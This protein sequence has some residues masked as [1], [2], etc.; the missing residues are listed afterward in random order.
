MYRISV[1]MATRNEGAIISRTLASIKWADELVLVDSGS[2]DDTVEIAK[3]YGAKVFQE[4]WKGYGAQVN[5]ALDKC[6]SPWILTLD[7]DEVV[8]K[9]L[10]TEIRSL[11]LAEPE[12]DAYTVPR[13]NFVLG[14]AMLHGGLYP[15]RRLRLFRNGAAR[16][17]EDEEHHSSPVASVR[18]GR[19]SSPL[20]HYQYPTLDLYL[21]HM[22]RYSTTCV[23]RL[24]QQKEVGERSLRL[25]WNI[26][27][28][29][30]WMFFKNYVLRAGF[31]DGR[32]ALIY[33]LNHSLYVHWK[34]VKAWDACRRSRPS[35]MQISPA[36]WEFHHDHS[37]F[38]PLDETDIEAPKSERS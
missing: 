38:F 16:L 8:S 1:A 4:D 17:P 34:Y 25:L 14:K 21:E 36:D 26:V 6:T 19:L 28:K 35:N 37:V 24:M 2:T 9:E 11:L 3:R 15:D 32:E 12:F 18:T 27:A 31:L 33:H 13:L 20:L 29:P 23:P 7:A 10:A 22:N 5:S 30:A